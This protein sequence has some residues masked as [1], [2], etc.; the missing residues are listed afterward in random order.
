MNDQDVRVGAPAVPA[1]PTAI[2][3]K[4]DRVPSIFPVHR[5]WKIAFVVAVI[6]VLL[7]MLGVAL[8]TAS[9]AAASVYWISLVPIYGLLCIGTAWARSKA[10]GGLDRSE[11]LRQLFHWLGIG[12]ALG[13]DF[14]IRGTGEESALGAG[15]NAL[16]LL[17]VGCYLAGIHFEWLFVPVGV[18]LTIALV[19]VTKADQY[20][21]LIFL[22]GVLA[23]VAMFGL[24][25]VLGPRRRRKAAAAQA[26]HPVP[27][28][29]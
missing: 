1:P 4:E 3:D 27:S 7:A 25:W 16:L 17:A 22:V 12:V 14:Y 23:I 15:L 9:K 19:I 21:W 2:S 8:S 10:D 26:A 24:M 29:S 28:G 5:S 18:L 6:M 13:L 11:V 20:L